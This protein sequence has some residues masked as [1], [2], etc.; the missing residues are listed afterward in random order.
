[1]CRYTVENHS[2]HG[3]Y[4]NV[5]QSGW[6]QEKV[7]SCNDSSGCFVIEYRNCTVNVIN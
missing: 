2:F 5:L 6:I 7:S 4:T 3:K 1:M